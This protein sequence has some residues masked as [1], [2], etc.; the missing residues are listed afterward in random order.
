MSQQTDLTLK[1]RPSRQ[2]ASLTEKN[3]APSLLEESEWTLFNKWVN[4]NT[5]NKAK[6]VKTI[7]SSVSR[8]QTLES[9]VNQTITVHAD[10]IKS[11]E[12]WLKQ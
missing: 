2:A 6:N 3:V 9:A 1:T 5:Q 12:K 4:R 11:F 8:S 7:L 10:K